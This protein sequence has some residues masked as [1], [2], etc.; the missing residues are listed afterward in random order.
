MSRLLL[1]DDHTL[2]RDALKILL[3]QNLPGCELVEAPTLKDALSILSSSPSFD[4]ALVD[5]N[6]PDAKQVEAPRVLCGQYPSLPVII[7]S[8]TE[9]RDIIMQAV[10]LGARGFISKAD[11]SQLMLSTIQLVLAGG[12]SIPTHFLDEDP[13]AGRPINRNMLSGRQM[14]VLVFLVE[15]MSNK[16]IAQRLGISEVTVKV[17]VHNILKAMGASS[18]SK[19]AALARMHGLVDSSDEMSSAL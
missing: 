13:N 4:L 5:L 10:S 2:F 7:V 16:E 14:E 15:G 3:H 18:R 11:S 17:H 1:V 19:A 6:L 9:R 12:T 8:M